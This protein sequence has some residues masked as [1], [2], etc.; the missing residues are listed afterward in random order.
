[1]VI[2]CAKNEGE[3]PL[4]LI[5][6]LRDEGRVG[7]NEKAT[8]A[9]RLDPMA[10]GEMIILT[11]EDV[12]RKEEFLGFDKEYDVEVL[13][14]FETDSF[15][16][17]GK[18][19][20][21]SETMPIRG[22]VKDVLDD[23]IGRF[24]QEYP[25][26]SSKIIAMESVPDEMPKREVEIYSLE[27]RNFKAIDSTELLESIVTRINKVKGNFRQQEIINSWKDNIQDLH[28]AY[29]IASVKCRCSSGTYMRSLADRI[30][31]KMGIPALAYSIRR[32]SIF[33]K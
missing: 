7:H 10:S 31:K 15:D 25:R 33:T 11:G 17:L 2:Y 23:C 21:T 30:G 29:A 14:G 5:E 20:S 18:V 24:E 28:Q 27:L 6:R 13:F 32:T 9:G 8:Y 3:T 26:Y 4:E 16:I 22:S 12:L 19:V 1:M